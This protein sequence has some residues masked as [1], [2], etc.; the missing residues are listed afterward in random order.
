MNS[1]GRR[2]GDGRYFVNGSSAWLKSHCACAIPEQSFAPP[3]PGHP[4]LSR[5]IA[6]IESVFTPFDAAQVSTFR[7]SATVVTSVFFG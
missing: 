1:H 5:W 4:P 7:A 2:D 6:Q 3:L